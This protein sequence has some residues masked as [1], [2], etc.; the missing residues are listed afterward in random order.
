MFVICYIIF[1]SFIFFLI[2]L[3]KSHVKVDINDFSL[4]KD[5][6]Q[7][8]FEKFNL[9]YKIDLNLKL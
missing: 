7:I 2:S 8:K 5:L 3:Q 6:S 9:Y 4:S 1:F